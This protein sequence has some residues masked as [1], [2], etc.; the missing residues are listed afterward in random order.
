MR[1]ILTP[2]RYKQLS[3]EAELGNQDAIDE[4][5][6]HARSKGFEN[7]HKYWGK[8]NDD[9][10][11]SINTI[12]QDPA[13]SALLERSNDPYILA[14]P[15][16]SVW[17]DIIDEIE[18]SEL[19]AKIRVR[20]SCPRPLELGS[21]RRDE[22]NEKIETNQLIIKPIELTN[23]ENCALMW[24]DRDCLVKNLP[25]FL[26]DWFDDHKHYYTPYKIKKVLH[27]LEKKG[28]IKK[29]SNGRY[30]RVNKSL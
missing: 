13:I 17:N 18:V 4:L 10:T 16:L 30:K 24:V 27:N 26:S 21:T 2:M 14:D 23:V 22:G 5:N 20:M 11:N 12:K 3:K 25:E 9:L 29:G 15:I 1:K 7:W 19:L 6:A 8:T 28:Q